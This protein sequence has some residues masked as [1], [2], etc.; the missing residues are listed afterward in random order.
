MKQPKKL[1]RSQK[2]CLSAHSLDWREWKLVEETDLYYRIIHKT[3]G[4]ELQV[5]K[6]RKRK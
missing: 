4:R 3:D 6:R 5:D 1:T 2:E